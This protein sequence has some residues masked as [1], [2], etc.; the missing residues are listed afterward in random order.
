MV[1][2][3]FGCPEANYSTQ[4]DQRRRMPGCR[5]GA[6]TAWY[7]ER[8]GHHGTGW[9]ER[10]ATVVTG[11]VF[12]YIWRCQSIHCFVDQKTQLES[13]PLSHSQPVEIVM[14][15]RS[16]MVSTVSSEY[17][18]HCTVQH[19]LEQLSMSC[20]L[21]NCNSLLRGCCSCS[22]PALLQ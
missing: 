1:S 13:D 3:L 16:Y 4:S 8:G 10:V 11:I 18:S 21:R 9:A 2:V 12:F 6:C 15:H 20:L 5:V 17:N 19:A 7:V 14:K 22:S